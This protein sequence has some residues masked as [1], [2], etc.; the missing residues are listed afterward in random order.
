MRTSR[1]SCIL[2]HIL[3]LS[4]LPFKISSSQRTQAENLIKWKN[5][6]SS[7]SS[8]DSWSL[9]NLQNL[10]NWTG[11]VCDTTG[12]IYEIN[13]SNANLT[14]TL[15]QLNFTS[16]P[17]LTHFGINHNH[18]TGLIPSTIANL[19]KLNFLDLSHNVFYGNIPLEI[20]QLTELQYLSVSNNS[21]NGTIPYQLS[22]LQKVWYLDLGS[23]HLESPDWSNFAGMP[24][25]THLNLSRNELTLKF[26]DFIQNSQNLTYLDLGGI[27]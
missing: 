22:N 26:P 13:L 9:A 8:L 12:T 25:L 2:L 7:P 1:K 20:G 11:I 21:L 18:F 24:L 17:N 27:N 14:G 10:C 15:S 4:I 5:S 16:F 19:S 3:L 6:L 23:N